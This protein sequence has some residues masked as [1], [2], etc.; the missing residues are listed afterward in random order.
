MRKCVAFDDLDSAYPLVDDRGCSDKEILS[1]FEYD[2][3]E[4]LA[5]ARIFSMFR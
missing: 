1:Q 3:D 4:G 2:D 5:S